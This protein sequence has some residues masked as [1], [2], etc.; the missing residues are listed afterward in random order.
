MNMITYW[1]IKTIIW[2]CNYVWYERSTHWKTSVQKKI[3]DVIKEKQPIT[4]REIGAIVKKPTRSLSF[5]ISSLQ[6]K[7]LVVL[8]DHY[9]TVTANESF[10]TK[11]PKQP[12]NVNVNDIHDSEHEEWLTMVRKNKQEKLLRQQAA[13]RC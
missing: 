12:S 11:L 8:N 6:T 4:I 3:Y 1:I 7:E 2:R 9:F 5:A 10:Y 13:M